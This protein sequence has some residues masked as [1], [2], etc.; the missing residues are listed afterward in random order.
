MKVM[1]CRII[2]LTTLIIFSVNFCYAQPVSEW[3]G[4]GRSGIYTETGLLKEWP[5][6]GPAVLWEASE[7]GTGYSSVT[8]TD[9]AVYITGRKGENDVLTSFSQNGKKNWE[10][11]YGKAWMKNFPESR[12]TPTFSNGKLFL[13]SGMG[14]MV[15]ITT[16]GKI[17]W[18]VNYFEKFNGKIPQF[19]ISESPLVVDNKVIGT[20]GG[21]KASVIAL[22]L[23]D[24]KTVWE[25]ESVKD[26][27]HYVNPLLVDF[28]GKRII[29][30]LTDSYIIG[31]DALTGKLMWKFNYTAENSSP[32]VRKNH[33]NTPIFRDGFLFVSSGYDNVALKLKLPADGSV[34]TVVWKNNDLDPHVGGAVLLGNYL[35]GSNW[36][37]NSF[38]KW[39]CVDWTTG[40]TLWINDWYNKGSIIAADGMLYIYEEKSGHVGLV[41]PGI[42][43]LEVVSQFQ[44]KK[45]TGPH[46][47]H[48]VIDKGR[49]FVRHGD[50][51]GVYSVK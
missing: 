26:E 19:G 36:E 35:Y 10:V 30:T 33:T 25:T 16:E 18:S 37:T 50:Y 21:D 12:C 28:K 27:T 7:I 46:W 3:R 20:P 29:I 1:N 44:I 11:I 23:N 45:G 9:D 32:D 31:V 4:P 14:N 38:G 43:K 24:G 49:L 15:C 22:N 13:V 48:P 51:L 6:D 5:S 47:A 40:K 8:V 34:P 17:V 39:V 2:L 41:K 42:E